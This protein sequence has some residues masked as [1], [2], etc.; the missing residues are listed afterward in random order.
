MKNFI[1]SFLTAVVIGAL[2]LPAMQIESDWSLNQSED[3]SIYLEE[4]TSA[5]HAILDDQYLLVENH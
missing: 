5:D 3:E 4:L 1:S 2:I